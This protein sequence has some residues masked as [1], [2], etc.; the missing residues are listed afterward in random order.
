MQNK[1]V[2]LKGNDY[3]TIENLPIHIQRT[4]HEEAECVEYH[5]H[6]FTE[7]TIV[8]EGRGYHIIEDHKIPISAGN[9]FLIQK[10]TSHRFVEIEHLTVLNIIFDNSVISKYCIDIESTPGYKYLFDMSSNIEKNKDRIHL[11]Y[12]DEMILSK[13]VTEADLVINEINKRQAGFKLSILTG[14]MKILL[15][16]L[17]NCK[18]DTGQ[19]YNHS[20]EISNILRYIEKEYKNKITLGKL[21]K[22]GK[23]SVSTMRKQFKRSTKFSPIDYLLRL[24]LEKAAFLLISTTLPITEVAYKSGFTDCSYFAKQFKKITKLTPT[25]VRKKH[26]FNLSLLTPS[27]N[28]SLQMNTNY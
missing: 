3:F 9:V 17:R 16:I 24:R 1:S 22:V 11:I 18:L 13:I 21:A 5:S 14:F 7:L 26:E 27:S 12:I 20:Y 19:F 23:M 6:D 8:Q 15:N 28:I 4:A 25:T 10:D 2:Q